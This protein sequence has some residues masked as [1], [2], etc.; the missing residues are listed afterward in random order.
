M[1]RT[2]LFMAFFSSLAPIPGPRS[3]PEPPAIYMTCARVCADCQLQC[4]ACYK[5]CLG[6]VARGAKEHARTLELC[7]DCAQCCGLGAAL[8]AR[9]GPLAGHACDCCAKCCDECAAACDKM[10]GDEIM[11]RC[12]KEC[13]AC[14]KV[15]RDM[16]QRVTAG[17]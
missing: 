10:A 16:V 9:R 15:C 11:A 5:H 2:A 1:S 4:D 14:A 8:S 12:G 17:K 6:L 13:R 3:D 7:A